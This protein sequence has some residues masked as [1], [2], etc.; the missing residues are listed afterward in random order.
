[1]EDQSLKLVTEQETWLRANGLP[2]VVP[3]RRRLVGLITRTVPLLL[4]FAFFAASLLIADA[5]IAAEQTIDLDQL[6][7]HPTVVRAMLTALAIALLAIPFGLGYARIQRRFPVRVRVVVGLVIIFLWVAG[8]S[9]ASSII[10]TTGDLHL[11]LWERL[12]LL[13]LAAAIS[14]IEVDRILIWA[15]RRSLRELAAAIPAVARIL[16]LLLLTVLLVFFTNELWQLAAT[17]SKGQMVALCIFLIVMLVV[18]IVPAI[19]DMLDE[20]DTDDDND[21]LL[22]ATPFHGVAPSRSKFSIGE[23]INLVVVSAAVQLVQA[24]IFIAATFGIFA[25]FGKIALNPKLI[26]TWTGTSPKAL[27]WLGI[28]LPMDAAMFRVCLILAL[29]SGI[30]F[31][32]STLSDN[33]YRS[34]FLGRIADEMRRNIAARHRYRSTLRSCGKLPNRWSDM[35][36]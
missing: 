12:G 18:I 30:S 25:V 32:A 15:G 2:L 11:N 21:Q 27:H 10:P 4:T 9:I 8:L 13:V 5:A 35:V 6:Q 24:A 23:W 34:L 33:M 16:P 3:P 14:F 1:M 29:F 7:N 28:N 36:A 19:I 20:E 26:Q 17:M 31:A 22:E